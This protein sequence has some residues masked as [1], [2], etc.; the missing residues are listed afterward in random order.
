MA[1]LIF[2]ISLIAFMFTALGEKGMIF[3]FYQSWIS[4]LPDWIS[5]PL[6]K[7]Y[8]CFTGQ[9]MFWY[10]L[11]THPF[12]FWELAFFVSGGIFLSVIYYKIWSDD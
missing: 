5:W 1:L 12:D 4:K 11:F 8:K 3:E 6:G 2:K 10:F 7:C 9:V